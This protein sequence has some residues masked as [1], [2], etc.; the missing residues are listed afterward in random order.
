MASSIDDY[1]QVKMAN[2]IASPCFTVAELDDSNVAIVFDVVFRRKFV[3][4][5]DPSP[6]ALKPILAAHPFLFICFAQFTC[7]WFWKCLKVDA[8]LR[9]SLEWNISAND[10]VAI[11][12]N[13]FVVRAFLL[14]LI[15]ESGPDMVDLHAFSIFW[16]GTFLVNIATDDA[17]QVWVLNDSPDIGMR[18]YKVKPS[19]RIERALH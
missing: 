19:I 5:L 7:D 2:L 15:E 13:I 8:S 11:A 9:R 6:N 12:P 4:F 17:G 10:V 3:S 14:E 18:L 16:A 1:A